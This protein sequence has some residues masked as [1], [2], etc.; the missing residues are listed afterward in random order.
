MPRSKMPK[1]LLILQHTIARDA[2]YP[3]APQLHERLKKIE[4]SAQ[5][6]IKELT[7]FRMNAL[8]RGDKEQIEK[9][10]ELLDGLQT[11]ATL[12][13]SVRNRSPRKQGKGKLYPESASGPDALEL[14][15]LM[16]GLVWEEETGKWP[17]KNNTTAQQTCEIFWK[18]AAGVGGGGAG[19]TRWRDHLKAARKRVELNDPTVQYLRRVLGFAPTKKIHKPAADSDRATHAEAEAMAGE[20]E[21]Y[22]M[23]TVA[24]P[25]R[26]VGRKRFNPGR[27]D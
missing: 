22:S 2:D 4:H 7:D 17:G 23:E 25:L 11:I 12:A 20:L 9:E 5:L 24:I 21:Q 1:L 6:L 8:L 27:N 18:S 26:R 16:M 19:I 13:A 3:R 15:A 14:C 10:T